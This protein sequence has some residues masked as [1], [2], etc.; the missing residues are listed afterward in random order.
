[1]HFAEH[2]AL[3][4]VFGSDL[5]DVF[6]VRHPAPY[7]EARGAACTLSTDGRAHVMAACAGP[8]TL[9]R[10]ELFDPGWQA[11]V[12]GTP[13]P[14]AAVDEIFQAVSLPSG[15]SDV[16]FRYAPPGI[17]RAYAAALLGLLALAAGLGR[18]R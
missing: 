6:E 13:A 11:E 5:A 1:L 7:V 12:N 3:P 16:R 10:R 2:P 18:R 15:H 4:R 8:A 9:L 14:V 17:G